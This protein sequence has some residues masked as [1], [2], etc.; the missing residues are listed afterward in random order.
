MVMNYLK[1]NPVGIDKDIQ[2]MQIKLFDNLGFDNFEG[3][4]RAYIDTQKDSVKPIFF[5][6]GI[7]YKELLLDDSINGRFFFVEDPETDSEMTMSESKVDIIFLVNLVKLYPDIPYRADEEFRQHIYK[8]L[9][10]SRH[11]FLNDIKITKGI[12]ALKGFKT[13]LVDMHPYHF[14]KFSGE[15]KYQLDN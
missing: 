11:F 5:Q 8:I 6:S 1:E 15:I 14:V 13:N 7:D 12:E 4:G 2:K 9:K 3:Y 10:K